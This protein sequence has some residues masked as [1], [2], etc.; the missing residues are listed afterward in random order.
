MINI[1]MLE[2]FLNRENI[3]YAL[4]FRLSDISYLKV[5]GTAPIF[6]T[7]ANKAELIKVVGVLKEYCL[8]YIFIGNASNILFSDKI[9]DKVFVS[10]KELNI[11]EFGANIGTVSAE[12]GVML[13]ALAKAVCDK[14][15]TGFE[16]LIGIPGTVGGAV[17]MNAGAYGNE[18][19]DNII[20]I[21]YISENGD[22]LQMQR[23]EADFRFRYSVFQS[24]RNK[25]VLSV[26]FGMK[27]D[28]QQE[29]NAKV[30]QFKLNR[31]TYQERKYPNLGS[32]FKTKDIY[33]DIAVKNHGY[34][35]LLCFIRKL[36][37]FYGRRDNIILNY[38]TQ[39][40]FGIDYIG[41]KPYSDKTLNC[42]V[43]RGNLNFSKAVKFI[44]QIKRIL[45]GSAELEIE[46][47]E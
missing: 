19:S 33:S 4:N 7:P 41:D 18:I 37:F 35:V 17:C 24:Q 9:I 39:K 1:G 46:V 16:G 29:I 27:A 2:P 40:Y 12:T 36:S 8:E 43:N 34:A 38:C 47:L 6:I 31:N 25:Q 42:L 11:I 10:T 26:K 21:E 13:P 20:G 15:L 44:E 5:G 23:V 30:Q 14:G 22:V 3:G 28:I 45:G 32:L